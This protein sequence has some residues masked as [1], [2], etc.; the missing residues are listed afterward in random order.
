MGAVYRGI[1]RQTGN[2]VAIKHLRPDLADSDK[3]ERFK[4]EGEIL[5][6]L[7]HP[8]I[9]QLLHTVETNG[10]QYLIM[11]LMEGGS[12]R[13]LLNGPQPLEIQLVLG[14]SI[15]IVDALTRAHHL[16]VIHRDIKPANVLL[17][18]DGTPRLTDFGIARTEESDITETGT[19]M[20]TV[21][22]I[23][24][25]ILL[26]K[27]TDSRSDIWSF[28]VMLYEM[29]TGTV[30]FKGDHIGAVVHSILNDPVPDIETLRSDVPADLID[31]TYR[32][33]AKGPAERI[34]SFRLVGA[35]LESIMQGR[36]SISSHAK[37]PLVQ[38]DITD[39]KHLVDNLPAPATPFLGRAAEVT[40]L[41][42]LLGSSDVRLIT[43]LAQ[44]GMGKTRL[45]LE[46]ARRIRSRFPQSVTFVPLARIQSAEY[47]VQTI[48]EELGLSL[49][50]KDDPKVQL[51]DY[52][53]TAGMLL[54]LDNFEHLLDGSNLVQEILKSSSGLKILATSRERLNLQ[55][56]VLYNLPSMKV[57]D[58]GTVDEA[59]SYSSA[60]LFLQGAKRVRIDFALKDR[61]VHGLARICRRVEG[62]PLGILLAAAWVETFSVDEIADEV[63]TSFDF[64]ETELRDVPN[65]QRSIR[66]VLDSTWRRLDPSDQDLFVILSVFRASFTRGAA[67]V[68][69]G[70]SIRGL[71]KLISKSLLTRDAESGRYHI[72]ELLRQYAQEQL[73]RSP[74]SMERAQEAHATFFADFMKDRWSHLKDYRI[75]TAL[76]EIGDDIENVRAA[77]RYWL[78]KR[79]AEQLRKFFGSLWLSYETWSWIRP[80]IDLFREARSLLEDNPSP[81]LKAIAAYAL[82]EEGWFTSLLGSPDQGL[83]MARKSI[84]ALR[85]LKGDNELFL[86]FSSLNINGIFV[87]QMDEVFTA[88][89]GMLDQARAKGD[90]WEE[91]FGLVW[92]AFA[93]MARGEFGEAQQTAEDALAVF[94]EL[95][96]DFGISVAAGIVLGAISM[97]QGKFDE[98][99]VMYAKGLAAAKR[100]DYRRVVQLT[101]DSVGT[102]SLLQSKVDAAHSYFLKS[103]KITFE[104]GQTREQLGSL[105]D[106]AT[107]YQLQGELERAMELLAVILH[108][109]AAEQNS[110]SRRESLKTE[111]EALRAE[112]EKMLGP[113]RSNSAW[114]RGR[115]YEFG[116]VVAGLLM[117]DQ[118]EWQQTLQVSA[119]G[120]AN[121]QLN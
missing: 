19:V 113:V 40:E 99:E 89:Q 75:G 46:V 5:R 50:S 11:E 107:V 85:Q 64:L 101:Y 71:A 92:S 105:R 116:K 55:S 56:E 49:T 45:A 51:L 27:G 26:G 36:G 83:V 37:V 34:P 57:A 31:L 29:L 16:K 35:E 2:A 41:E 78:E 90:R 17:A 112:I 91:G 82:A 13:D 18:P 77:W 70:A 98:A 72:H 100:I 62:M 48:A 67:Q 33:L 24:P 20:G 9:V 86:P 96:N 84:A 39:S 63:E 115:S 97:A 14:M 120:S 117:E 28:G 54:V 52:L 60:Q 66:S 59:M 4:R 104:S 110:L 114:E 111:A 30:P 69:A 74:D 102:I 15:E 106:I 1:D 94:E 7:N 121:H 79:N 81:E 22:Y 6:R 61:D 80:A 44:G 68:V 42:Q 73:G 118:N 47:L 93:V 58:W 65:S 25:E 119:R 32:M 109:P 10:E 8:N 21:S 43:I 12:L 53:K 3:V 76:K 23:S 38:S 103:L 88:S 95:Q 108:H 87:N